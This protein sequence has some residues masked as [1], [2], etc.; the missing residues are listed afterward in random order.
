MEQS[1]FWN[2]VRLAL[3]VILLLMVFSSCTIVRHDQ[4]KNAQKGENSTSSS[5]STSFDAQ[6]FVLGI[7]DDKIVP[8]LTDNAVDLK[9]IIDGLKADR[10]KFEKKYGRR[11]EE[12]SSYNYIVK[13]TYAV[14]SVLTASAAGVIE[15]NLKDVSG[16]NDVQIQIGPVIKGS[17]VRDVLPFIRFGDFENQIQFAGISREINIYLR[18]HILKSL[19]TE[20]LVGKNI[21]FIGAFTW[22]N[23]GSVLITPI[24]ISRKGS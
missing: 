17:T 16:Q 4:E 19:D 18:D 12:T 11:Q 20:G 5:G 1:Y 9:I 24:S 15:L 3:P 22:N 8:E 21:D 6:Q 13:G 23:D 2:K 7:W 10:D 14:K